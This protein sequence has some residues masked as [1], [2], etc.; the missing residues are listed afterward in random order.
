M[1]VLINAYFL[2]FI[3]V[4]FI[5]DANK[6]LRACEN[7]RFLNDNKSSNQSINIAGVPQFASIIMVTACINPNG[8]R[9]VLCQDGYCDTAKGG[10][11][12][13]QGHNDKLYGNYLFSTKLNKAKAKFSLI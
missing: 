8:K 1:K 6:N 4:F 5:V 2:V 7:N 10:K 9:G 13:C 12:I 3:L 11:A